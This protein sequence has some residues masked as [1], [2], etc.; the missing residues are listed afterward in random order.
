VAQRP[1]ELT[2]LA[3]ARH[4]FGAELRYWRNRRGLSLAQLGRAVY[5]SA[6]LIGKMKKA[7]R[8]PRA[9][10]VDQFEGV[11]D[12]GGILRRLYTL[13]H[14]N[15]RTSSAWIRVGDIGDN[16]LPATV[17]VIMAVSSCPR[18]LNRREWLCPW[19]ASLGATGPRTAAAVVNLDAARTRRAGRRPRG[20]L[21]V[22]PR[23][24][25]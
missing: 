25:R 5:V 19:R 10:L 20:V 3:S 8:W 4:F 11:L 23:R 7:Q 22:A 16:T 21:A 2:P 6:D 18:C 12:A 15:R 24:S 17:V 14:D 1:A 9:A 13:A